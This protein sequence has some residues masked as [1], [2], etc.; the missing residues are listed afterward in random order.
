MVE[1][2]PTNAKHIGDTGSVLGSERS[3]GEK[4]GNG[5][6]AWKI[7]WTEEPGGVQSIGSQRV[8]HNWAHIHG[9]QTSRPVLPTASFLFWVSL[10]NVDDEIP[11]TTCVFKGFSSGSLTRLNHFVYVMKKS[12]KQLRSLFSKPLKSE[13]QPWS[14]LI[15]AC[16]FD[17]VGL[18]A[19]NIFT[20]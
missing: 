12:A 3:P 20:T 8:R 7:P 5:V 9:S 19:S 6:L 14:V 1:N 10:H 2:P 17:S 15:Q 16:I 18:W 4:K 11:I 13:S